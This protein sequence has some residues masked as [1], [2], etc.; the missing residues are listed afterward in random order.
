MHLLFLYWN[1]RKANGFI[2]AEFGPFQLRIKLGFNILLDGAEVTDLK[3]NGA[4][5]SAF[6]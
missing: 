5:V 1:L 3:K 4:Y 6:L 2:L